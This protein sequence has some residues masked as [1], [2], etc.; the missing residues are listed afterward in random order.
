MSSTVACHIHGEQEQTFVCCH[1][2]SALRT[3]EK[4]GFFWACE[5]RGDAWCAACEEVRVREGGESGD[6]NEKSEAFASIQIL[7]SA[8][9]DRVRSQHGF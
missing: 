9:Y 2:V 7:C 1:L 4:V 3:G 5:P 6:W 8:C